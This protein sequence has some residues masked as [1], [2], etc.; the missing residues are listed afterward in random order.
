ML[1]IITWDKGCKPAHVIERT[2]H[3]FEY[4]M[5]AFQLVNAA[6]YEDVEIGTT[7]SVFFDA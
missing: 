5:S 7:D 6:I 1:R 4:G 3:P 2:Y